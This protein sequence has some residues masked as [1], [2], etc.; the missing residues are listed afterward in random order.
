[1]KEMGK[2]LQVFIFLC[3][4]SYVIAQCDCTNCPLTLPTS[5]SAVSTITVS[6]A[7]N[8]TLGQNGQDLRAIHINMVHDAIDELDISIISPNG[9]NIVLTEQS[10]FSIGQNIT[11]DICFLACG[12]VAEPDPGFPAIF[13][14]GAGYQANSTYT[15]SYYPSDNPLCFEA[16]SGPVNG[17]W[18]LE[19]FDGVGADGGTL[20]DWSL[21]FYD[22][23]GTTCVSN[24][25]GASCLADGGDINGTFAD[26]FCV[27]DPALNYDL[28]PSY[29][30]TPPD[31]AL[32]G[33]TYVIYDTNSGVILGYDPD[34]DLTSFGPG[35]YTFCGLSYLIS[36]FPN[37]PGPN[38]TY[39][40]VNLNQDIN[41]S[42]FCAD[43][44]S[45]G[46]CQ[47]VVIEEGP[48]TPIVSGPD[49]VCESEI[50]TYVIE[51]YNPSFTYNVIFNQGSF[52]SINIIGDQIE[53]GLLS[54]PAEFCVEAE[55]SCGTSPQT[56]ITVEVTPNPPAIVVTGPDVVCPGQ[57]YTYTIQ[58]PL[59]PGESYNIQITG[60]TLINQSGNTI[61][62][63]WFQSG[64]NVLI[65]NIDGAPCPYPSGTLAVT[66]DTY[67]FPPSFNS[68]FEGCIGDTLFSFINPDPDII[69]YVWSGN[70]AILIPQPDPNEIRYIPLSPGVTEICLEVE[71]D[72]GFF[73]P[74]CETI[75]INEAP[76]PEISPVGFVCAL[77]FPISAQVPGG[78]DELSWTS[79]NGPGTLTFN[80]DNTAN[81]QVIASEPGI[82]SI[83]V[84]ATRDNCVG[85]DTIEIEIGGIPDTLNFNIEC[86]LNGNYT[87]SF[88]IEGGTA[89]YTV[90]GTTIN[91]NSFTSAPIASGDNYSFDIVDDNNCFIT[92]S[93]SFDCPCITDAGTMS[94]NLLEACL[95][96][97]ELVTAT[98]NG[99]ETLDN[100]DMGLYFLHDGNGNVLGTI[101]DQNA[102][103]TFG[104]VPG[105]IPGQTYYISFVVG[106]DDNG[107]IDLNDPCLSVAPGQPVIFYENPAL[108]INGDLF[109]CTPTFT[110]SAQVSA[111]TNLLFWSQAAGPGQ[112]TFTD[113]TSDLTVVSVSEPGVYTY[114]LEGSN[115]ACDEV[116]TFDFTVY[117]PISVNILS[118]ECISSTEYI[119]EFDI[120]G[121]N[122]NY[123]VDIPGT[124]NGS[125][126]TSDP[127]NTA[128]TYTI[129]VSD[130]N[131][132]FT[133][134]DFGPVVC[135][136][137]TE[138]GSM[139][140]DLIELCITSDSIFFDLIQNATLEDD[141]TSGFVIHSGA[142]NVINGFIDY[143]GTTNIAIPSSLEP[144]TLYYFSQVAG[145]DLNGTVD[146]NDPCL[147]VAAGQP[148]RLIPPPD[149]SITD[150]TVE[151]G[152]SATTSIL[153]SNSQGTINILSDTSGSGLNFSINNNE[154]LWQADIDVSL[155][156]SYTESNTLC[157]R[158]DT[159]T[160]ELLGGPQI[161]NF[162]TNCLGDSFSYSFDISGGTE[163]YFFNGNPLNGNSF[164][165]DTLSTD[166]IFTILIEDSNGCSALPLEVEVDCSCINESGSLQNALLELCEGRNIDLSL[167]NWADSILE[168][169]DTSL[170]LLLDGP[171]PASANVVAQQNGGSINYNDFTL[172]DTFYIFIATGDL[173]NGSLDFNDPCLDF[174]NALP[175]I[176]YPINQVEASGTFEACLGD[177]VTIP[178]D[179]SGFFPYTITLDSDQGRSASFTID[180][181]DNS[182]NLEVSFDREIWTI[183]DISG[184]CESVDLNSFEI[185]GQDPLSVQFNTPDSICNDPA[186]GS[187]LDLN[188]LLTD[189]FSGTWSSTQVPINGSIADFAGLAE[190]TY[191]LTFSTVGFEDPCPGNSFNIDIPVIDCE[192][193]QVSIPSSLELCN[194][195][196]PYNLSDLNL[197][198]SGNWAVINLNNLNRP[199]LLRGSLLDFQNADPGSY[200]LRYTLSVNFPPTCNSEFDVPLSVFEAPSAGE[201]TIFPILCEDVDTTIDLNTLLTN[202]DPSGQWFFEGQNI[203]PLISINDFSDELLIFTY[204][205]PQNGPCPAVQSDVAIELASP[206][207]Y[208]LSIIDVSCFGFSD[209][210]IE[211]ETQDP[212]ADSWQFFLDGQEV[213]NP[214]T[215]LSAGTY[216]LSIL[217]QAGCSSTEEIR[218]Q[219]P[220]ELT[221][222]LG[223]DLQVD[224]GSTVEIIAD[225][226]IDTALIGSVQWL[227]NGEAAGFNDFQF[228]LLIQNNTLFN[229]SIEDDEGCAATDQKTITVAN[230]EFYIPNVFRPN[231]D[232]NENAR[233]GIE[234]NG[235]A[236]IKTFQ[237]YD[238]WGN[239]MFEVRNIPVGSADS[240]WLGITNGQRAHEGVYVYSVELQLP[241][242][243]TQFL[244]GDVTLVP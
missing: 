115:P 13:D 131:D 215:S 197:E 48:T 69:D 51:N 55:S 100:D 107:S 154:I 187:T 236:L 230:G 5:G 25:C 119:L 199:P 6:G 207:I 128:L 94:S 104:F 77:S 41:A 124:L 125:S 83:V 10:G 87:V 40:I 177:S 233:F 142:G 102:T 184:L 71:T 214:I 219:Q 33:Y 209:A 63:E 54:G 220:Q 43:L 18:R 185:R 74:E 73:G 161:I 99:D 20:F 225:P 30:G 193:P 186:F 36:D 170:F 155:S 179:P 134:F 4:S 174:S 136:C 14:S 231:S 46:T 105:M 109:S 203:D 223:P 235:N 237:V 206:P 16:L 98:T 164:N 157:T 45:G 213:S 29:S 201:Q 2:V 156:F 62:I 191:S 89:P 146:L 139:S 150:S 67:V 37:I 168:P 126:F 49:T 200:I 229:I 84:T 97:G 152:L 137:F 1:M 195:N 188:T 244:K 26:T 86:D 228:S 80:P 165:G 232:I 169:T 88:D 151:C 194:I 9:G 148:F 121:G 196:S 224:P 123:T 56:C 175:V 82:Y 47:W 118:S 111:N 44:S 17:D 35:N 28:P 210:S 159:F 132:C 59:G 190:G 163:P 211:F 95:D 21:E 217:N 93:G 162:Q 90:N 140:P 108:S 178:I 57:T 110:L 181:S 127:L 205:V 12:E 23:S 39:S 222:D 238:R 173:L 81:T 52:S 240:Y 70:N 76:E 53:I 85:A 138:A 50:A 189:N 208:T 32:Y 42:L 58:T 24:Q 117:E 61:E 103:G 120:S 141:D 239:R 145:N 143:F 11:F 202:A 243:S 221:V 176:W 144:N 180:S 113:P 19:I 216:N 72:C 7:T 65:V 234:G 183:I 64:S 31:P 147:D 130:D 167:V 172:L 182:I 92:V 226:S 114:Q 153:N 8:G 158:T 106:N 78:F 38:G 22:N 122:G 60:G 15:G 198:L 34:A 101:F 171:D 133:T 241:D 212:E 66:L 227:I 68:P 242:G 204:S 129:T 79:F 75:T 192:C 112:S 116:L 27:G 96:D 166:S 135:D 3:L 91:G 218:I 160:L 149:F